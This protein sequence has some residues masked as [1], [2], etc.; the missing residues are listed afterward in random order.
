MFETIANGGDQ[1]RRCRKVLSRLWVAAPRKVS[2]SPGLF[3]K[4]ASDGCPERTKIL[5]IVICRRQRL[6]S[7]RIVLHNRQADIAISAS[8]LPSERVFRMAPQYNGWFL[9]VLIS[10]LTGIT[11]AL[12]YQG[13]TKAL[14][15][16]YQGIT[17]ALPRHYQGITKALPRH[18]QGITKAL[19]RH[20]QGITKALPRHYQGITKALPRHYQGITK[21]LPRHYQG[22]TKALP[23]HYQDSFSNTQCA[24]RKY[25]MT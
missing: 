6:I 24:P 20:Y 13:I 10:R 17:K 18:Y 16:H 3:V 15:R 12:L 25:M 2:G 21:A 4:G 1:S 5:L 14:L 7:P 11:K 22:I 19:P 9:T 23:R 8:T